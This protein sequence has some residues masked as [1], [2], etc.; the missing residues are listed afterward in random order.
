MAWFSLPNNQKAVL[1][2]IFVPYEPAPYELVV[3]FYVPSSSLVLCVHASNTGCRKQIMDFSIT[4]LSNFVRNWIK[5]YSILQIEREREREIEI[6]SRY[7]EYVWWWTKI[8]TGRSSQLPL[9]LSSFTTLIT[10]TVGYMGSSFFL[11]FQLA[12][13]RR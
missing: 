12:S 4:P 13:I 9:W 8:L 3:V 2:M 1:I 5:I 11:I 7:Q 10:G 6:I